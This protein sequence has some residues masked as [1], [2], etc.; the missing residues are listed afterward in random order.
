M[1]FVCVEFMKQRM[2]MFEARKALT[3][4]VETSS[5]DED[6]SHYKELQKLSDDEFKETAKK[7]V[8]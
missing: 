6:L 3:E 5:G 4:L 2:T 1:C 8:K 7:H